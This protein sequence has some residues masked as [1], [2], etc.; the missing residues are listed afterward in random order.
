MAT[1][2]GY[3]TI[4]ATT[5]NRILTDKDI[6]LRDLMNHFYTRKGERVMNPE[7][8]CVIWD[9]VFDPLDL[10]T[11]NLIKEDIERIVKSDPRWILDSLVIEK[12][13]DH[14]ISARV[15]I[16]YDDTGTAEQLYLTFVGEIE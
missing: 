7:F 5:I 14:T 12:P 4:D 15:Q 2:I 16:Y 10:L 8:G 11:E 3:S 13:D 9:L 1:Y 6:A